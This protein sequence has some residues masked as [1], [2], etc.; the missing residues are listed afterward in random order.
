MVLPPSVMAFLDLAIWWSIRE[1][2]DQNFVNCNLP[3]QNQSQQSL[4]IICCKTGDSFG[5]QL[6]AFANPENSY[7]Q[8]SEVETQKWNKER[9]IKVKTFPKPLQTSAKKDGI[10]YRCPL[11]PDPLLWVQKL[12]LKYVS[13]YWSTEMPVVGERSEFGAIYGA[14]LF[15]AH[16][17]CGALCRTSA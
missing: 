2:R 3:N 1:E 17:Y 9:I 6:P 13:D 16:F 8:E 15:A 10:I 12:P 14:V 7:S 4:Q 5:Q 11:K